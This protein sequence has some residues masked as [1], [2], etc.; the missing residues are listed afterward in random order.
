M[1]GMCCTV[2]NGREEGSNRG[3]YGLKKGAWDFKFAISDFGL[4]RLDP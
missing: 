4:L 1:M 2:E 3:S